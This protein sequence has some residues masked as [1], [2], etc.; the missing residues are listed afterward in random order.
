M[1]LRK[2]GQSRSRFARV[3]GDG[4]REGD[5][6]LLYSLPWLIAALIM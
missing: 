5:S 2:G 1:G 6:H 4:G 3:D